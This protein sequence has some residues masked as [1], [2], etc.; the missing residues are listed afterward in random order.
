[1]IEAIGLLAGLCTTV[2]FLPQ[3][4]K[5]WRTRSTGDISLIMFLVLTAGV[6]LWLIY[7]LI[8]GDLPLVL[9]NGVTLVLVASILF[10]KARFG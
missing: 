5:C 1:M 2:S 8:L 4:V 9:A 7:G 10:M 3:A 6:I